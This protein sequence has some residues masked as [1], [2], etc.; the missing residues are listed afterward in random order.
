M[1]PWECSDEQHLHYVVARLLVQLLFSA[2]QKLHVL[3]QIKGYSYESSRPEVFWKKMFLK[4][5]QK[6][7]DSNSVRVSFLIKLQVSGQQ[8]WL[9]LKPGPRPWTRTQKNLDPEK[10]GTWKT[11][12]LKNLDLKKPGPW[13]TGTLKTLEPEKRGPWKTWQ[14][15]DAVKR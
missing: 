13:K 12:T 9:L 15:L 14:Q 8:L 7:Q 1:H 6:S 5:S 4:I 2:F 10:P 3:L 11:W